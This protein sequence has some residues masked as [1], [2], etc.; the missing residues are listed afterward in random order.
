MNRITKKF[1]ELRKRRE[2]AFIAFITAGDPSLKATEA[3]VIAFERIGVDIVELGVPFSDPLADGPT[4]QASSQRALGKGVTLDK[5]FQLVSRIRQ[6]SNMPIALMT[7][8]NPVFH[9]GEEQFIKKARSSGVDGV[10]IPDLPPEESHKLTQAARKN[11]L[12]TV[13]FI[14][15]TTTK[16]RMQLIAKASTGFIYYVSLTGVT[17]ARSKLP[18]T[19]KSQVRLAKR[20]T[21]KPVCVGFGVSTKEQVRAVAKIADGVIIGSA[22]VNQIYKTRGSVKKVSAFVDQLMKGLR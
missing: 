20:L 15:P 2:K 1:N 13:F 6:K 18:E 17:G 21:A 10:I 9:R 7:Y 8:F 11:D 12:A 14:A 19:I 5:I 16:K 4:I 22:I 3:L